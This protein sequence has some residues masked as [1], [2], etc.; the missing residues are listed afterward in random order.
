VTEPDRSSVKISK[1]CEH[2]VIMNEV[3]KACDQLSNVFHAE[4][5]IEPSQPGEAVM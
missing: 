5:S 4:P 3:F 1:Y 2:A